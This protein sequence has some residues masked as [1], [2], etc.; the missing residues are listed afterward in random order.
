MTTGAERLTAARRADS[1]A[2]RERVLKAL[3]Y[4]RK[5]HLPIN[6]ARVAARAGVHRNFVSKNRDLA[7]AVLA[8]QQSALDLDNSSR[9]PMSGESLRTDLAIARLRVAELEAQVMAL[10]TRLSHAGPTQDGAAFEQHPTLVAARTRIAEL[11]AQVLVQDRQL[12]EQTRD[13]EALREANRDLARE[14]MRSS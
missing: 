8:A 12:Q 14:L 2:R 1:V 13:N 5:N 7:A 3:E 10:E 9:H 6:Q 4:L 11:E